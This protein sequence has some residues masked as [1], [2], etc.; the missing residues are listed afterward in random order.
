MSTDHPV[1]RIL[2]RVALERHHFLTILQVCKSDSATIGST[3][4]IAL[5]KLLFFFRMA[6]NDFLT[7]ADFLI[8]RSEVGA[9]RKFEC[10][11]CGLYQDV[12][13]DNAINHRCVDV[14]QT[15]INNWPP[16]LV[17]YLHS[18][19]EQVRYN[20]DQGF[21]R[22]WV[23]CKR[24]DPQRT[25]PFRTNLDGDLNHFQTHLEVHDDIQDRQR[26]DDAFDMIAHAVR[27]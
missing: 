8:I 21:N 9:T 22:I 20:H 14:F 2:N 25:R 23:V 11:L 7:A 3:L 5:Y 16:E 26:R 6:N 24:C 19:K 12:P 1:N 17:R 4:L 27:D 15:Q 13:A 18:I 10:L